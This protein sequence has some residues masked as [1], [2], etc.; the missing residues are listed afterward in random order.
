MYILSEIPIRLSNLFYTNRFVFLGVNVDFENTMHS[1]LVKCNNFINYKVLP[2]F[3]FG[4][5]NLESSQLLQTDVTPERKCINNYRFS[6]A[7]FIFPIMFALV[8][9]RNKRRR[10]KA[11]FACIM[12]LLSITKPNI[13]TKNYILKSTYEIL[14]MS[15]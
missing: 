15:L 1:D 10:V 5:I 4:F 7:L 14:L 6:L 8:F 2:A 13:L 9:L 11:F 12:F 3:D